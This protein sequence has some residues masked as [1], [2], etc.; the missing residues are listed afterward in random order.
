MNS[1]PWAQ[2]SWGQTSAPILTYSV[3]QL[4]Q[5]TDG[6]HFMCG[7][8]RGYWKFPYLVKNVIETQEKTRAEFIV[9]EKAA[10]GPALLEVLCEHYPAK[11]RQRL[12]QPWTPKHSKEDRMAK[13][14]VLVEAGRVFLPE[15][16]EWLPH[17]ITELQEFPARLNDDQ[18]DA[19]SQAVDFFRRFQTSRYNPSYKGGGRVICT[20]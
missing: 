14:M 11:I 16:A 3:V 5:I 7:S 4:Y 6:N 9:I 20:W 12:L 1:D 10:S 19:L 15:S 8:R 17:L 18:V 2:S 13:A